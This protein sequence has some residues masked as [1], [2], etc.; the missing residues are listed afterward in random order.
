MIN[1]GILKWGDFLGYWCRSNI[2]KRALIRGR[3]ESQIK[4]KMCVWKPRSERK[5]DAT[6]LALEMEERFRNQGT[7]VASS[8]EPGIDFPL[9]STEGI[10]LCGPILD[11]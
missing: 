1:L 11:F 7:Q 9:K 6:L 5:E 3:Q 4:E 2:I 10:R 8:L